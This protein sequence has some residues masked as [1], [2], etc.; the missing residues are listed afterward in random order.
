[1]LIG[2]VENPAPSPGKHGCGNVSGSFSSCM[3]TAVRISEK[4]LSGRHMPEITEEYIM[5]R[6]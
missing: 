2:W 3:Q 5:I 6:S 1:M 4:Q